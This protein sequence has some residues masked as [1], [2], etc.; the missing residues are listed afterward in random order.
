M[1]AAIVF[2]YKSV[3]NYFIFQKIEVITSSKI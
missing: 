3:G 1:R 2:V